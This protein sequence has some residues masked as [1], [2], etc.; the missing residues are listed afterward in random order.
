MEII[1]EQFA[2][3]TDLSAAMTLFAEGQQTA[4]DG[5]NAAKSS[6]R[7]AMQGLIFRLDQSTTA[8]HMLCGELKHI[9]RE[10]D[11]DGKLTT[12]ERSIAPDVDEFNLLH[13]TLGPMITGMHTVY[14]ESLNIRIEAEATARAKA[15][16]EQEAH[17][18]EIAEGKK[19]KQERRKEK[20]KFNIQP[21]GQITGKLTK[22]KPAA[23]TTKKPKKLQSEESETEGTSGKTEVSD[24]EGMMEPSDDDIDSNNASAEHSS[25]DDDGPSE[26]P[27]EEGTITTTIVTEVEPKKKL[28]KKG[29]LMSGTR[30]LTDQIEKLKDDYTIQNWADVML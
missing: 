9:F 2:R 15:V 30:W 29:Q 11:D 10:A 12:D 19:K 20:L 26:E 4:S 24:I 1:D 16:A 3:V 18:A 25:T 28:A 21:T 23:K 8:I 17:K 22:M 14:S 7:C 5:N 27:D 6:V 13:D